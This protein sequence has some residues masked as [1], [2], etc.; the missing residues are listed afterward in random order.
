M[1]APV[2]RL[3]S[4]RLFLGM[5]CI[6]NFTVHQMDVKSAFLNGILQ[7]E[8][9]V[10]QPK[11]FED[12]MKPEYVFKLKKAL[13]GLK[14]APRAW[15]ERLT[16]F[17]L[18]K[19]Y[20]RGSIDKTLFILEENKEIMMV[21][22]YVDDIIFGSTS[23][24]LVD[25]FIENMTRE[26][27]M[28]LVGELKY[29]LGLQIVQS[30]E[31]IY[32]SQ[33]TY[34]KKIL[35]KFQMDKCKEAKTPMSTSLKLSRDENGTDV[36]VKTYRG[37]IGSL[38]YLTESRPDLCLSVG[39]CARYQAKPKQSHL[40]AVKRIL[41]YV[42]GTVELGIWYSR[43][44]NQNLVGYCDADYAGNVND[45]RSTSGGCFFLGNNLIAWLS[46]KKNSVSISTAE[47]EYIAMGSCCTQLLWMKQ[48]LSDYRIDSG[49][50]QVYCD[51]QSAIDISKNPVQHSRTKHIDVRHHFIR[52][53]VEEKKVKIDHVGTEIQLADVFTKALDFNSSQIATMVK[54]TRR[55]PT[56]GRRLVKDVR[57]NGCA[58][59]PQLIDEPIEE[60]VRSTVAP[61]SLV[62]YDSKED[63]F[64]T[65]SEG[66]KS[67]ESGEKKQDEV[68]SKKSYKDTEVLFEQIEDN[69]LEEEVVP[70]ETVPANAE[71]TEAGSTEGIENLANQIEEPV[72]ISSQNAEVR[73]QYEKN[74]EDSTEQTVIGTHA[75][76]VRDES[77]HISDI[78][79]EPTEL[80]VEEQ[81][82]KNQKEKEARKKRVF[83]Q[84]GLAPPKKKQKNAESSSKKSK[85][86]KASGSGK[87]NKFLGFKE[88]N[89]DELKVDSEA[90]SI[91][92]E[93]LAEILTEEEKT[94]WDALVVKN[95]SP[96]IGALLRITAQNWIP[97]S[98]PDYVSV[99]RAQLIYKIF[100]GIRFDVGKLIFNQVMSLVQ[101]KD[102]RHLVFPR[103]I[104][105][106]L[107]SQKE[108]PIY[109]EEK[110]VNP[111]FYKKDVRTGFAY[112]ERME[113]K[114][115]AKTQQ[116]TSRTAPQVASASSSQFNPEY[117]GYAVVDIGSIRLP[118]PDGDDREGMFVALLDT[119]Q[120][121]SRMN[122]VL[123]RHKIKK[124]EIEDADSEGVPELSQDTSRIVI[125]DFGI[126][127][128]INIV[129]LS[130]SLPSTKDMPPMYIRNDRQVQAFMKKLAEFR[131]G[132]QLC[133]KTSTNPMM[134][135]SNISISSESNTDPYS[136][137]QVM[138]EMRF[139]STIPERVRTETESFS[140]ISEGS[141]PVGGST[142]SASSNTLY[143]GKLFKDKKEMGRQMQL[144]AMEN[145]FEF[146]TKKSDS[147]R[148]ILRCIDEKCSWR[149]R[150]TRVK[151]SYSFIIKKYVSE[152]C[153]DSSLRKVNHR[154]ATTRTLGEMISN[155]FRGEKLALKP[156][157]LIEKFRHDNGI[158]V[159]YSKAWRAKD[160]AIDVAR[161]TPDDG[162]EFLP[163]WMYMVNEKNP[164]SVTFIEVDPDNKFKYAFLAF[165]PSIRGFKLMRKVICIDGAH[166]KSNFK[167]TLLGASAQDGDFHLY[168]IAFGVVDLENDASWDWFMKCLKKI[169]PD[170]PDLVF[171]S[172]RASSIANALIVNYPLA[173]HGICIFHLEK[174]LETGFKSS[175]TLI[176]VMKDAAYAYTRF[177]FE[178]L[179]HVKKWSRACA[180]ANRYNIMTSNLVESLNSLLK[181]SREYPIVCLF[182]TIRST[183]TRWFNERHEKGTRNR[184]S[185]SLSVMKQ[186]KT[187][188]DSTAR[189]LEVSQVNQHV[190]EVK[191]GTLV[192]VVNLE[193]RDCTCRV[194]N[195]TKIPCAHA[196]AA[197]KHINLNEY[198]YVDTLYS[199]KRWT[200]AYSES[201][202][203]VGDRTQWE[204]PPD[205]A[206]FVC[207]PP[208]SRV[209]SGMPKKKRIPSG[210]EYGKS[211]RNYKCR[212]CGQNGHNKSSCV[213]PI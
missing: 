16:N 101:N 179:L 104:Y 145:N 189:W 164:G 127:V 45:R 39:V 178:H 23:Q 203:P 60:P 172:D 120:A 93:K 133:G 134:G 70:T 187:L 15:Y 65:A 185:V 209:P 166:L 26:F 33:S 124:G 80:T 41:K 201:I 148:Y 162:Y 48:M 67:G 157:Q 180:P 151:A 8:V 126:D 113:A 146:R 49:V 202:Y 9:Y 205:V 64:A 31:G 85:S 7:E 181:E 89:K 34:A 129:N 62:P 94:S 169:I 212:R 3:E 11:G 198:D 135:T 191:G 142:I 103:I 56:G 118:Q 131:G 143:C 68:E 107:M 158:G 87:I 12:M 155:H 10:E 4:I 105:G 115:K 92:K 99:E 141:A 54:A 108:V 100:H 195:I 91:G 73:N 197:A 106:M 21:Q 188:Y 149:L 204:V 84:L 43:N 136:T 159:S 208:S 114:A 50:L 125:E 153:C 171:V 66:T 72:L 138:N 117:Q 194:F 47:S 46:K 186:V 52:E 168:P 14:Q 20:N 154:Q 28:S 95:L 170:E 206:A 184:H 161:G 102:E 76:R 199:N 88:L 44:S 25:Q 79:L 139:D 2:A 150:A 167:G 96:R 144:F 75:E 51:N 29:F 32:I 190:F 122:E 69:K 19:G 37:M 63:S 128:G 175:S 22:I 137:Y 156:K 97:S 130:Y 86:L 61:L 18:E 38:L 36:D 160:H 90:D 6:L 121:I 132:I 123:E 196:I 183:L 147:T 119:A 27:E 200:L 116:N 177:D 5:A 83:K 58:G 111:K 35:K 71:S 192:H 193:T 207:R 152:H 174:N 55:G 213:V 176:P 163:M 112:T 17:L 57:S 98:N 82:Q 165:G 110:F 211:A 53:L 24:K 40:E 77:V 13:Y 210:W 140:N 182:D 30:D 109:S 42:R 59:N 74:Q 78:Q 1:F 81:F 173:H